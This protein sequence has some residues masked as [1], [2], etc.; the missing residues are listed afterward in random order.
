M[1]LQLK[2]FDITT[3]EL[4]FNWLQDPQLKQLTESPEITTSAQ[5]NWFR[6]LP[7]DDTY[8]IKAVY[9]N[10]TSVGVVG[11]KKI[12]HLTKQAEYF[13]YIGDKQFWGQGIGQ[14]M[15]DKCIERAIELA[16]ELIYL[17][18][19]VENITAINLYVKKGFKIKQFAT[20]RYRME[21]ILKVI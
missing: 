2:D 19:I 16:L 3:L 18:V 17:Q 15:L 1:S 7:F 12:D 10:E 5:M 11:L 6:N 9:F 21:K 4:S 20:G 13:G 8:W 14:W